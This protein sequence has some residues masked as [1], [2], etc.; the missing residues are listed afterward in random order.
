MIEAVTLPVDVEAAVAKLIQLPPEQ[1]IEISERLIASLP[2]D[3]EEYWDREIARRIEDF[4]SG[5]TRSSPA[6][7][8]VER[9][10][11]RIDEA[12]SDQ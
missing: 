5:R 3:L 1:R 8:V 10:R 9:L 4:E 7:E 6:D 12:D 2:D 11:R